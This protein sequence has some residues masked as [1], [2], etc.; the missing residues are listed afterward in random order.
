[1]CSS[2]LEVEIEGSPFALP[3]GGTLAFGD[4][5][6][7]GTLAP[8]ELLL[9]TFEARALDGFVTGNARLRWSNAWSLEGEIAVR[10]IDAS[11]IAAPLVSAGR[12]EG[13]GN[14]VMRAPSADRLESTA[15]LEGAFVVQ[16]GTLGTVDLT[17]LLQGSG[18]PGGNTLFSE[19]TGNV[20]ASAAGTQVRQVRLIAGLLNATGDVAL[21][22]Q[23]NLAGRLQ[24]EL[25]TPGG[26]QARG[27]LSLGGTLSSPQVRR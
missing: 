17:Q 12:M 26:T 13:K 21:D 8:A 20:V 2:D 11:V 25:R 18:A 14:Y 6:A 10:N 1:M 5:K 24:A 9:S 16:K 23:K 3:F 27:A 15:R 22:P 19:M 4:F 7:S